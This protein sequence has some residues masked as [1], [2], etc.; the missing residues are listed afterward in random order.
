MPTASCQ[1]TWDVLGGLIMPSKDEVDSSDCTSQLA[2]IVIVVR[3]L[4]YFRW[5]FWRVGKLYILEN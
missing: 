1:C 2:N 5:F 3:F 4:V